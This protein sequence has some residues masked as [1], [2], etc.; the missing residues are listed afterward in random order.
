MVAPAERELL[1]D[2]AELGR[3][4]PSQ[5]GR[6]VRQANAGNRRIQYDTDTVLYT[7]ASGDGSALHEPTEELRGLRGFRSQNGG[8]IRTTAVE[9]A[10]RS[11]ALGNRPPLRPTWVMVGACGTP[12]TDTTE[13]HWAL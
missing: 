13:Q 10:G 6:L 11:A 9:S 8:Q 1:E 5:C 2:G 7:R 12:G 3:F 4:I